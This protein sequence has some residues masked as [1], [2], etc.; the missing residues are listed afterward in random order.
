M[1]TNRLAL[2]LALAPW[3]AAAPMAGASPVFTTLYGVAEDSDSLHTIASATA[4]PA[5]VGDLL[6]EASNTD[7]AYDTSTGT[8]YMS[9]ASTDS[10]AQTGL[11]RVDLETGVATFIGD[12]GSSINIAGLAYDKLDGKLYGSDMDTNQLVTVDR[13]TGATTAVGPFGIVGM[14]DL[15]YN[16][17]T[18]TL[19]GIDGFSLFIVDRHTGN[20]SF[21]GSLGSFSFSNLM[22]ALAFDPASGQ[23][24]GGDW[25]GTFGPGRNASLYVI[26]P[27]T[28]HATA[29]GQ[30][31]LHLLGAL[32]FGP[33]RQRILADGF[34]AGLA[35]WSAAASPEP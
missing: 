21:I 30:T 9:D 7:L 6:V 28:G 16:P 1:R 5:K 24:Y 35:G 19:Y 2:L 18:D 31:G 12:H 14:R 26:S 13:A 11:A 22:D 15:A 34:E 20:A 25:G 4:T 27:V 3:L 8:L 23:L 17:S 32:E 29:I 10:Y 33:V